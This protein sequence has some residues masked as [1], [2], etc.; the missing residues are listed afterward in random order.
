MTSVTTYNQPNIHP[1]KTEL[2]KLKCKQA[3]PKPATRMAVYDRSYTH[4]NIFKNVSAKRI[5]NRSK[6]TER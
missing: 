3:Y 1:N 5:F 6:C 4:G 2:R